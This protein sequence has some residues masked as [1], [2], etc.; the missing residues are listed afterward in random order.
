MDN[1]AFEQVQKPERNLEQNRLNFIEAIR[2]TEINE[3]ETEFDQLS[4]DSLNAE[5]ESSKL[6]LLGET[7]GVK[8]NV[9]IIYTLFKRFGFKRLGLEW[10]KK[11]QKEVE[12][13]LETGE[14]NFEVIEDEPDGRITAGHFALIKKLKEEDL[15]EKLV[16]FDQSSFSDDQSIRDGMMAQNIM[17]NLSLSVTLVVAGNLH[18]KTASFV[19]KKDGKT[20]YP[21]GEYVKKEIP[22]VPSGRIKYLSGQYHNYGINDFEEDG[23]ETKPLKASFYISDDG[24]YMFDLPEAHSAVV[25]DPSQVLKKK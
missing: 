22:A 7:H 8:E 2:N 1:K 25:P 6:F 10:N 4:V 21:M 14:L 23:I 9:D 3:I 20:F 17:D 15:L 24:L 5:L 18:T 19:D 11:L 12:C 13:F 16:C